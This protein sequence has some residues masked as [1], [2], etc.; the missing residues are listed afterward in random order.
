MFAVAEN[1][2]KTPQTGRADL[3][4]TRQQE[5]TERQILSAIERVKTPK[6]NILD[7]LEPALKSRFRGYADRATHSELR[8]RGSGA[9]L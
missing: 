4:V 7:E 5:V 1:R 8:R 2:H 6:L 3:Q 9:S